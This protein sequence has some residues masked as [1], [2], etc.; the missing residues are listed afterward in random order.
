MSYESVKS[1]Q[2]REFRVVLQISV[3]GQKEMDMFGDQFSKNL[4]TPVEW[5]ESFHNIHCK[6]LQKFREDFL[7][8]YENFNID[9][10]KKFKRHYQCSQEGRLKFVEKKKILQ[11]N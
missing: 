2:G 6:L 8:E 1:A 11:K 5:R 10:G 7:L 3:E 4:V 9:R